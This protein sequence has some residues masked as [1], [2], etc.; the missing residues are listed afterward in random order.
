MMYP[1]CPPWVEWYSPWTPPQM[2]LH[3]G[4]LGLTKGF[5]HGGYY[6]G[7]DRYGSVGHQQDMKTQ[8]KENWPVRNAKSDHPISPKATTVSDQQHR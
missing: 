2:H 4:W 6:T 8:R 3:L 5:G 1:S 7:D